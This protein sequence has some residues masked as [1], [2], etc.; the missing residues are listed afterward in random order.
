V[1]LA[2]FLVLGV[3]VLLLY[4]LVTERASLDAIG[5]GVLVA[6]V[7]LGEIVRIFDPDFDPNVGLLGVHDALAGFG[8]SAVL[9]IA[10]LYIIGEGLNRTGAVEFIARWVMR[11]SQNRERRMVL[12]VSLIAGVMSAFLNNTGVVVVFIPILVG[13]AKDSGVAASRLLIPLAFASILGGMVTLV[14][15]STNL[16]VSGVAQDAG[17]APLSMFE[18]TPVGIVIL[19][20]GVLFISVFVRRLLPER[21]SLSAMMAGPGS[22]EYVTELS[23]SPT[24]PLLGQKYDEIFASS[25]AEL[26]F[27]ARDDTMVMPSYA[28]H[29]IQKG[30][31]IMLRGNVDTLAGLQDEFGLRLL[32]ETRFDPKSMQF[33]EL[34]ISPHSSIVGRTVGD[35]HLWR[36]YGAILV[37]VLRDGRH[38]RERASKQ[39]LHAGDLLLVSGDEESQNRVRAQNDFFLLTGAHDWVVLRGKARL[40]LGLAVLVMALFSLCSLGGVVHLLPVI[41][42]FGALAMVGSGCLTT[43]RAYQSIDWPILLFVVGTIGLGKAM[44]HSGVASFL[45]GGIVDSLMGFGPMAVLGGVLLLCGV[46]TNFI[47]NQAVAVLLTPIAIGA[48]KQVQAIEGLSETEFEPVVRSFILAVAFGASISFA[49]PVGHQSN[50]MV[51]GPGGYKFSD[52]MR[53]GVPV[54]IVCLIIAYFGIPLITGMSF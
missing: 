33:F 12:L 5:I 20:A 13:L 2:G 45:A 54:S 42:L 46:L 36:D 17:Y 40:S 23:I 30:D 25:R 9:T 49:T 11:Y 8:N 6:L 39:V 22:R 44:E 51:Y 18:M 37:A 50:L 19:L 4:L 43:R 10:S 47:S 28:G 32:A 7:A 26:L 1:E 53:M 34:A 29:T 16:L 35:L 31:V 3:T 41:A 27:Y 48:A 15:T 14:G 38:I 24:S 52:Y 21:Q